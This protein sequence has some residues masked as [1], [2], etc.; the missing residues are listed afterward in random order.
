MFRALTMLCIGGLLTACSKSESE[1]TPTDPTNK[2]YKD[3]LASAQMK[4]DV[5]TVIEGSLKIQALKWEM[6]KNFTNNFKLRGIKEYDPWNTANWDRFYE[7][8]TEIGQHADR[9]A[10]ATQNLYDKGVL[11]T[12]TPQTRVF[13]SIVSGYIKLKDKLHEGTEKILNTMKQPGMNNNQKWEEMYNSLQYSRDRLGCDNWHDWRNK[14]ANRDAGI[15]ESTEIFEQL[16]QNNEDFRMAA[17]NAG[18]GN[19]PVA[20]TTREVGGT[21]LEVAVDVY[22]NAAATGSGVI[23]LGKEAYDVVN[24]SGNFVKAVKDGE[25]IGQA[26]REVISTL[27]S[28]VAGHVGGDENNYILTE[29]FNAVQKTYKETIEKNLNEA[30]AA[31]NGANEETGTGVIEVVDKDTISSGNIV[32][33]EGP[34]GKTT[35]AFGKNGKTSVPVSDKGKYNLT[36]IDDTGDKNTT[37]VNV[38]EKGKKTSVE[39]KTNELELIDAREE[40]K[41]DWDIETDPEELVFDAGADMQVVVVITEY[42][43]LKASSENDWIDVEVSGRNLYV[44]VK[45]NNTGSVRKGQ[46]TIYASNDGV[47]VLKTATLS[48]TQMTPEA[49]SLSFINFKNLTVEIGKN[50]IGMVMADISYVNRLFNN[51]ELTIT[52]ISDAKYSVIGKRAVKDYFGPDGVLNSDENYL[53]KPNIPYGVYYDFSFNIEAVAPWLMVEKNN[54]RIT[55]LRIKGYRKFIEKNIYLDDDNAGADRYGVFDFYCSGLGISNIDTYEAGNGKIAVLSSANQECGDV[56]DEYNYEE[57]YYP[58]TLE[59][60][61]TDTYMTPKYEDEEYV[62]EDGKTKM[63]T[64]LAGYEPH[65]WSDTQVINKFGS[66]YISITLQW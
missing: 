41:Y 29:T 27:S 59:Y 49:S 63:R 25:N 39:I 43:E 58:F 21:A 16:C 20:E 14:I 15:I 28:V 8:A 66:S 37:D 48:V 47:K 60:T 44:D 23:G 12:K 10:E 40:D 7:L 45:E 5:G 34:D 54:I 35:I 38:D 30:E 32:I 62:D 24:V 57:S 52:R 2:E 18:Y 55:D 13:T 33:A 1:I 6:Y 50:N 65:E 4:S 9:Y 64:V 56:D 11:T 19:N 22:G 17:S 42:K 46:V 61:F 3:Y 31:E 51:S 36:T 53:V 26:G